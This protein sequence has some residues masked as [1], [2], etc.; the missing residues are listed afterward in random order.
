MAITW[1]S[2]Y[3]GL[4]PPSEW[5]WIVEGKRYHLRGV[6]DDVVTIAGKGDNPIYLLRNLTP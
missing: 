1:S 2:L 5:Q 4:C 3:F 6:C